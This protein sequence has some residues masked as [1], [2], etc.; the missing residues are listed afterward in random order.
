MLVLCYWATT[1][2]VGWLALWI[3]FRQAWPALFI[4]VSA[5]QNAGLVTLPD[6]LP[7]A[8]A[9]DA[10]APLCVI[11]VLICAGNTWFPILFR[12]FVW[13]AQAFSRDTQSRRVLTLLLRYPRTCYTHLFPDYATQ[14]LV[15]V[16]P[17]LI[18]VQIAAQCTID[19]WAIPANGASGPAMLKG[20]TWGRRFL[21]IWFQSVST[22]TAGFSAVNL[23]LLS[24]TSAF[25]T[26]V[27]MWISVSPQVAVMRSTTT[28]RSPTATLEASETGKEHLDSQRRRHAG[29]LMDQFSHFMHQYSF[30]LLCLFF[31]ILVAETHR[32]DENQVKHNFLAIMFEFCSA[33][34]TV[35]L[36]MFCPLGAYRWSSAELSPVSKLCFII[37]MF[38]G[39]LRGLPESIDRTFQLEPLETSEAEEDEED[40]DDQAREMVMLQEARVLD[41]RHLRN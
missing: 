40:K 24:P 8:D 1:Q 25:V 19:L 20:F 22:R 37:V 14:W 3:I 15:I 11:M 2:I 28:T 21:A 23:V 4:S 38:L 6:G 12:L 34:G 32:T 9:P 31:L 36:S 13:V 7:T 41:T 30:I 26:C 17:A 10:P 33:Y 35:G 5:F 29:M 18:V 27:C 39:R 16:T